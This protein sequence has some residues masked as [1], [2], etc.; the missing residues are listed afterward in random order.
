MP[1]DINQLRA[2]KGGDP[3]IVRASELKRCR[4]G[5]IVDEVIAL[6]EEWR[7]MRY[8]YEEKKQEFNKINKEIAK[9]RKESKGQDKCEEEQAQS[10]TLKAEIKTSEEELLKLEADRTE[11]IGKIGNIVHESVIAEKDEDHNAVV[12]SW[13]E[14][15]ERKIDG[16]PGNMHHHEIM[17]C[18]DIFETNPRGNKVAGHRGYFLKG[19]GVLLNQ[20]LINYSLSFLTGKDYTPLQPPF[21]MKRDLMHQTCELSDFEENLYSMEGGEYYLIATSEQP[22]SAL[23]AGEWLKE[24]QLPIK[25]AGIS[26]C[27]RKEAGA[28]G[29]DMWGIFRV[30]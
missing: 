29:R 9:R 26:S 8:A 19:A 12:Q 3:E 16:T 5:K 2:E 6:D 27:F 17:R 18:L 7:K 30:H 28:H 13:G 23:H 4:D 10:K 24:S 11:K 20:A 15:E 14:V 1:V 22:I 25:Y 21:F